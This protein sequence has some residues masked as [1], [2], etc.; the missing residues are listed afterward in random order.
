MVFV[1]SFLL[2]LISADYCR[3]DYNTK[4]GLFE[5]SIKATLVY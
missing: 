5:N 3:L 1:N 2:R 4:G